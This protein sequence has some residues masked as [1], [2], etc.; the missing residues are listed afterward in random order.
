VQKT[1]RLVRTQQLVTTLFVQFLPRGWKRGPCRRTL[2]V[3]PSIRPSRSCIISKRLNV[4][5]SPTFSPSGRHTIL[6]LPCQT[7]RYDWGKKYKKMVIFDQYLALGLMTV[8]VSSVVNSFDLRLS[9]FILY[10]TL[11]GSG[12]VYSSRLT[13]TQRTSES[14]RVVYSGG[15]MAPSWGR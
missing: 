11:S 14:S 5:Y 15:S 2:S 7:L 6:V 13:E 3:R 9:K 4:Q 1:S 12:S 10:S 8:G